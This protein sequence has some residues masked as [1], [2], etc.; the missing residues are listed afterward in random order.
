MLPI[1]LIA[2]VATLPI[3]GAVAQGLAPSWG[4]HLEIFEGFATVIA[5]CMIP[6]SVGLKYGL[7][8]IVSALI[9]AFVMHWLMNS[10]G[11]IFTSILTLIRLRPKT[12]EQIKA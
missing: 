8:P 12:A 11:S 5:F 7:P 10:I 9:I 4:R 6:L 2:L 3:M 1:I